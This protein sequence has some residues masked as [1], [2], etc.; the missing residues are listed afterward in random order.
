M[1]INVDFSELDE[2]LQRM[3]AKPVLILFSDEIQPL[4]Q[5]D[6]KLEKGITILD[7][8]DIDTKNGLLSYKGHQVL[9]YIQDHGSKIQMALHDG[10]QG[11]KFHVANC[12]T[13]RT[14]HAHGRYERYV[15]TNSLDG[16]FF[17]TGVD[18]QTKR[19]VEG[20]AKLWVC[21]NC[22]KALNYKGAMH[23]N[24][25][26]I[27]HGFNLGEFFST[28]SSLFTH[29]PQR[30]A[31]DPKDEVYTKDWPQIAMRFKAGKAFRCEICD[32]DLKEHKNLLH[33]HHRNGVKSDNRSSNLVVLCAAC[34][35]KQAYH[36]HMFVPHADMSKINQ[37]RA[38]QGKFRSANWNTVL[39]YC[40]PALHGLLDACRRTG[41]TLPEVGL[42]IQDSRG[43]IVANLELAW[44]STKV[45]VAINNK[46]LDASKTAGWRVWEIKTVLQDIKTFVAA[47]RNWMC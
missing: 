44:Q 26:Q 33:V 9:L 20:T 29:L 17:I 21:Q 42:N 24:T 23:E 22:L 40:D 36:G 6:I 2:A 45:G 28:Y 43:N 1:I 38:R 35:R 19:S 16:N 25:H 13:L 5:I 18:P 31:G 12:N 34:H 15:V 4:N 41:V 37:L 32:V 46:D 8:K 27:A 39:E 11:N 30:R 3:G 14:M 10:Q 7:I 47:T